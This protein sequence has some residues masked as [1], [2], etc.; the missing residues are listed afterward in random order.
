MP[1]LKSSVSGQPL[2]KF[3]VVLALSAVAL[4]SS[5]GVAAPVSAKVLS[6][7]DGGTCSI[8]DIG[9]GGGVVFFVKGTGAFTNTNEITDP[10]WGSKSDSNVSLTEAEQAA[11]PFDYL[12]AAPSSGIVERS[13]ASWNDYFG[14]IGITGSGAIGSGAANTQ[15]LISAFPGDDSSNNSAYYANGYTSNSTTG[16]FLPSRDEIALL[17][18]LHLQ[19]ALGSSDPLSGEHLDLANSYYDGCTFYYRY[20]VVYKDFGRNNTDVTT[21]VPVRAF[22]A[23]QTSSDPT[24]KPASAPSIRTVKLGDNKVRLAIWAPKS[25]GGSEITGYEYTVDAGVTWTPVNPLSTSNSLLITGLENGTHYVVKVRAVN[26][27]GGG[28][29]SKA[30]GATPRT[31]PSAPTITGITSG[32]GKVKVEFDAPVSNGGSAVTRYGYSI[33]GGRWINA[34]VTTSPHWVK[35]LTNGVTYSIRIKALNSA[36]WSVASDAFEATPHR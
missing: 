32:S 16:W 5:I 9:P 34:G 7:A 27:S 23:T 10:I 26:A 29:A 15:A 19:H 22:S 24:G 21:V 31:V 1:A 12:E 20:G 8:G 35:S 33:N 28:A 36:G 25:N 2:C 11:L 14:V 4:A 30:R 13:A 3:F 6:C 18:N 17:A